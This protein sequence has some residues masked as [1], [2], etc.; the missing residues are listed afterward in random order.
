LVLEQKIRACQNEPINSKS[1]SSLNKE[2]CEENG[3]WM[4]ENNTKMYFFIEME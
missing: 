2:E 1:W 3:N 4:E